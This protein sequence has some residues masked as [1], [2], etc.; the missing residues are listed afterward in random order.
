MFYFIQGLIA[1]TICCVIVTDMTDFPN[2]LKK[3]LSIFL[4]KGKIPTSNYTFHLIDCSLCQTTHLGNL[5]LLYNLI[6][7][8][9]FSIWYFPLVLGF[10]I[11]TRLIGSLITLLQDIFLTIINKIN[12]K[13]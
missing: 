13:L 6:F 4:T 7:L 10:A 5:W 8:N 3:L 11:S 12:E 2:S 9:N 1:I